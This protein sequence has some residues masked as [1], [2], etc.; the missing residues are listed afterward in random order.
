MWHA[1]LAIEQ[2]QCVYVSMVKNNSEKFNWWLRS[3]VPKWNKYSKKYSDQWGID[4]K[5]N[6]FSVLN[7]AIVILDLNEVYIMR[8][9]PFE[10]TLSNH[11]KK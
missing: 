1:V 11:K 2:H 8:L 4:L 7:Q 5:I 6:T 10:L 3:F 9:K